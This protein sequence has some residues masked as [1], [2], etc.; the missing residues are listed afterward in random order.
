MSDG[1]EGRGTDPPVFGAGGASGPVPVSPGRRLYDAGV[2]WVDDTM[3]IS[4]VFKQDVASCVQQLAPSFL[5]IG[6][7]DT[8]GI[9]KA[10]MA[11][12]HEFTAQYP[13]E[14]RPS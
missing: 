14:S 11:R 2:V 5:T 6:P 13:P 3:N 1:D 8:W 12:I 4:T 7:D 10:D 9:S